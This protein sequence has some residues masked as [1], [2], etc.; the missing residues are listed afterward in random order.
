MAVHLCSG[1]WGILAAPFFMQTGLLFGG[2]EA[3]I[4]MLAWNALA[5]GAFALWYGSCSVLIF[6]FL[7]VL[8]LFRVDEAHEIQGLD[9]LKHNE[10]AYPIGE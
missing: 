5:C 8:K 4:M 3:A 6:G 2:G 9:V 1:L 7:M 10:P